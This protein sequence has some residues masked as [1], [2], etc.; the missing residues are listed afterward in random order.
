[1]KIFQVTQLE[2]LNSTF[3][4]RSEMDQH[5]TEFGQLQRVVQEQA[6]KIQQ[7]EGATGGVSGTP[8]G[9]QHVSVSV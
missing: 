3:F 4:K 7:L 6:T 9:K 2:T 5:M 1:M 8:S